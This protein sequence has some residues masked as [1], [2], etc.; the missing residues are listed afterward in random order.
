LFLDSGTQTF[1]RNKSKFSF[2]IAWF[3]VEGFSALVAKEWVSITWGSNALEKWQ[4]KICHV[5]QF[6]RGWARNLNSSYKVE[7]ERLLNI[8]DTL[9]KKDEIVQLNSGERSAMRSA[10]DELAKMRR[11]EE[12]RW[13]QWAKVNHVQEGV[14]ILNIFT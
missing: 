4:N 11:D 6:L 10:N 1:V 9:D 5:R 13:A 14:T 3:N 8:I 7:K 2:E 12:G